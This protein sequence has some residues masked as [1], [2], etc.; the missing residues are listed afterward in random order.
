MYFVARWNIFMTKDLD[1]PVFVI[2]TNQQVLPGILCE[3]GQY[4]TMGKSTKFAEYMLSKSSKLQMECNFTQIQAITPGFQ[5]QKEY[6]IG[7]N[8]ALV[9]LKII[10]SIMA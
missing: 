3:T 8:G 6:I 2:S 4:T 9:S 7:R 5:L 10:T 1:T